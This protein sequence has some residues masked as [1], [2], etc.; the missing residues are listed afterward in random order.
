MCDMSL[1]RATSG[2]LKSRSGRLLSTLSIL[3][4]LGPL[5]FLMPAGGCASSGAQVKDPDQQAVCQA[6]DGEGVTLIR[7]GRFAMAVV[8]IDPTLSDDAVVKVYR[9]VVDD[10]V[11][12]AVLVDEAPL[13]I[14]GRNWAGFRWET[15]DRVAP[16]SGR[17]LTGEFEGKR[18]VL[19]CEVRDA[20]KTAAAR[21]EERLA[22][23]ITSG[24]QG[25]TR[26]SVVELSRGPPAAERRS[27]GGEGE[28]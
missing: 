27:E 22:E 8:D 18:R 6:A 11:G 16:R 5:T 9:S 20:G 15:P 3:S 24:H 19:T 26:V 1:R 7:C 2:P 17:V 12:V 23:L 21:C 13:E 4:T 14:D 10:E 25:L 28:Q